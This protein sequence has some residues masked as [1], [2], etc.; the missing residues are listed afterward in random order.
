MAIT[1]RERWHLLLIHVTYI[2]GATSAEQN[3]RLVETMS[4]VIVGDVIP[5]VGRVSSP[6]GPTR[7]WNA[8]LHI[9]DVSAILLSSATCA[10]ED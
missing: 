9:H 1:C 4:R 2:A 3:C 8:P 7:T 6:P 10:P 5:G